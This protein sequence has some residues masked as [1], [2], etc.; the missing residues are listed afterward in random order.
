VV[1][2][3]SLFPLKLNSNAP[4]TDI[5]CTISTW[6]K[7]NYFPCNSTDE[8]Q[9]L[10]ASIVAVQT[11]CQNNSCLGTITQV[12]NILCQ[13]AACLATNCATVYWFWSTK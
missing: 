13:P 6:P 11:S 7:T 1:H 4:K 3:T 12:Q 9:F 8:F 10:P 2:S 5:L